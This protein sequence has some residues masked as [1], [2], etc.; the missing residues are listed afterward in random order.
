MKQ[1]PDKEALISE[2]QKFLQK[3]EVDGWLLFDFHKLNS[4][5]WQ[6]FQIPEKTHITRRVFYYIPKEGTAVKIA[7]KIEAHVLDSLPGDLKTYV[8]QDELIELLREQRGK[9]C[10]EYSKQIPYLSKVDGGT[11]D[12]LRDLGF[13]VVSSAPILQRLTAPLS[14]EQIQSHKEAA[15][16]VS[17]TAVAAF[18][19]IRKNVYEKK[20]I[21]EADVR[22]FIL[23]EF[24]K[25]QFFTEDPPIVARG[26]NSANPHY[27][28]QGRGSEIR[29]GDFVLIDLWGRLQKPGTVYADI[30]RVACLGE[31]TDRMRLVFDAVRGAQEIAFVFIKTEKS[32]RGCDVDTL[33]RKFLE[34]RGFQGNILHRTG[35]SIGTELHFSGAHLDSFEALDTRRL[36]PG[37]CYSI[38]PAVY[39]PGEFGLRLEH[40]ILVLE[41]D[42]V[43]TGGTQSEILQLL[44]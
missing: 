21:F 13:Q 27:S 33:C 34:D 30:T 7:H 16:I 29:E 15:G 23:S 6:I 22:D 39:L 14:A 8:S 35:H 44:P 12:V 1:T 17:E 10:M 24:E 37:T 28:L 32:P 42:V 43:I 2:I 11:V 5:F 36:I 18:E 26:A 19:M 31:P 4:F 3:E 38:E 25:W 9:V 20:P 41:D 40:D